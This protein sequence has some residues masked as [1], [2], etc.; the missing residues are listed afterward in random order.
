MES[1]HIKIN[2]ISVYWQG[3]NGNQNF[4]KGE[5]KQING[6]EQKVQKQIH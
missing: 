1:Q 3:A 5:D 6:I 4:R 2:H